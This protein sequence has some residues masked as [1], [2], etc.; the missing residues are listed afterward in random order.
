MEEEDLEVFFGGCR[1]VLKWNDMNCTRRLGGVNKLNL[2]LLIFT[3]DVSVA[4]NQTCVWKR[5]VKW[6]PTRIWS[7][8]GEVHDILQSKEV[9]L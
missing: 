6:I 1:K 8:F 7:K 2:N 5:L 3:P 9:P 4:T